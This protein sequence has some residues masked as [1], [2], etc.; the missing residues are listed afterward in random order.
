MFYC[1]VSLEQFDL[2]VDRIPSLPVLLVITVRP[3]FQPRWVTH[4]HVSAVSLDR[5][6]PRQSAALIERVTGGK[7]LPAPVLDQ[8]EAALAPFD[9]VPHW[10]KVFRMGGQ[11]LQRL[12]PRLGDFAELV[13]R[14]D[15]TG[16]LAN[17]YLRRNVLGL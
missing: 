16:K 17:D 7:A 10:G 2:V 15:P 5:F 14:Y 3:E 12:H 1:L 9:A 11:S 4:G 6:D 13:H 8:I